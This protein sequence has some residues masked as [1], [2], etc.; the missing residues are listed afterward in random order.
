MKI[1]ILAPIEDYSDRLFVVSTEY[2]Y[3]IDCMIPSL[4]LY[5]PTIVFVSR[6]QKACFGFPSYWLPFC[7]GSLLG[8]PVS[9]NL[10]QITGRHG[11][12]SL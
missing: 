9:L 3:H 8:P 11:T 7:L 5:H 6:P 10:E 2:K 1:Q 4:W 12:F